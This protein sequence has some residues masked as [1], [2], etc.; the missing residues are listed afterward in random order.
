[1]YLVWLLTNRRKYLTLV[2]ER[3][4]KAYK[5]ANISSKEWSNLLVLITNDNF[6]ALV[7]G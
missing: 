2:I 3:I 6:C 7:K 5:W 1:M 4:S